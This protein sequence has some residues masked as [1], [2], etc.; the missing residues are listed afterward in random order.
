MWFSEREGKWMVRSFAENYLWSTTHIFSG[1]LYAVWVP[2]EENQ[3]HI[4]RTTEDWHSTLKCHFIFRAHFLWWP[5]SIIIWYQNTH[6]DLHGATAGLWIGLFM[7]WN[8]SENNDGQYGD[9]LHLSPHPVI[10]N[11]AGKFT[12]YSPD[13]HWW[14][15][16]TMLLAVA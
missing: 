1:K 12:L 8:V 9:H 11:I 2:A 16:T 6:W 13:I 5:P 10:L 14:E 4:T 3:H 15:P 7:T